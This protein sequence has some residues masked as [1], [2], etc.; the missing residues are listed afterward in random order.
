MPRTAF[1]YRPAKEA[2]AAHHSYQQ[3][4]LAYDA[5]L[6]LELASRAAVRVPR[7]ARTPLQYVGPVVVRERSELLP[8]ATARERLAIDG[9]RLTV[10]LSMGGRR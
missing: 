1:I 8:R 5:I 6:V 7:R 10:F 9:D 2:F 3:A 4:L